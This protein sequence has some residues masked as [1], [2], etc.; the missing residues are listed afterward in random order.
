MKTK[1]TFIPVEIKTDYTHES[2]N[3]MELARQQ[4]ELASLY[5][6]SLFNSIK[7]L[8]SDLESRVSEKESEHCYDLRNLADIGYAVCNSIFRASSE[9]ETGEQPKAVLTV[10]EMISKLITS[11]DVP[12]PISDG[13]SQVMTDF[14]NEHIDQSEFINEAHSAAHI[15]RLLQ[16]YK[17]E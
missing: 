3:E 9:I 7:Y 8:A 6:H 15:E 2:G 16:A 10:A 14:H 11:P 1:Q 12:T 4:I 13:I 17:D 5:L